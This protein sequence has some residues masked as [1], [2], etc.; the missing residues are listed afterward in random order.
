MDRII[1]ENSRAN[2]CEDY[3]HVLLACLVAWAGGGI[4]VPG[5]PGLLS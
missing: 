2:Q 5:G 1:P 3:F 4:V